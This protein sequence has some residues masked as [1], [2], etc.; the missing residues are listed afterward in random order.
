[1]AV[2]AQGKAV[3]IYQMTETVDGTKVAGNYRKLPIK[4]FSLSPTENLQQEVVLSSPS[5]GRDAIDPFRDFLELSG[6]AVVPLDLTNIGHWL[7]MI[8]G[9]P[10]SSGT[11]NYTHVF[12]S[13]SNAIPSASFEKVYGDI[14]GANEGYTGVRASTWTLPIQPSGAA[15]CTIGLMGLSYTPNL[16]SAPGTPTVAAF[17]RF[18][19]FQG[20][21]ARNGSPLP[22]F[23]TG[24]I[25]FSNGMEAVKAI[26]NDR[27][28][29]GIDFGET[30]AQFEGS[31]RLSAANAPILTDA[32]AGTVCA[33]NYMLE[34][35]AN[36]SLLIEL[37]R[38]TLTPIG[39]R[40]E[41]PMGI[42]LPVRG[43]ASYDA[44]ATCTMRVTLKNQTATYT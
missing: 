20:S 41:G 39:P 23:M 44:T 13:G 34:I 9:A 21:V 26:R 11:T 2:G 10:A 4:S 22:A 31:V 27:R 42:D 36:K 19:R 18:Q 6:D 12:K 24:S 1:M 43:I 8:L 29:E 37:P 33:L 14:A 38:V 32:I 30:S 25:S 16:T 15:D 7:R 40:L 35:N 3:S 17:E 5:D 28:I